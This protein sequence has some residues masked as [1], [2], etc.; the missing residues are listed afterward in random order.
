MNIQTFNKV[1]KAALFAAPK[2]DT[3]YYLCGVLLDVN[4]AD[5]TYIVSTDGHRLLKIELKDT[6]DL[7]YGQ[8]ILPRE[9]VE[10]VL[11]ALSPKAKDDY[12]VNFDA[13]ENGSFTI[14]THNGRWETRPVDA[15]YPDYGRIVPSLD[16]Q[17]AMVCEVVMNP[18]YLIDAMKSAALLESKAPTVMLR[19]N[20]NNSPMRFDIT[21]GSSLDIESACMVVMPGR[22]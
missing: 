21:L 17:D 22:S 11:R 13:D 19:T 14:S 1:F 7:P 20:D 12:S 15:T 6:I 16:K 18:N 4:E 2:N 10:S 9:Y 3:R 8:Y 5:T